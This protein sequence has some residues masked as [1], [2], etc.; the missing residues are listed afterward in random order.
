MG[1]V[2]IACNKAILHHEADY[3]VYM[4]DQFYDWY[5]DEVKGFNGMK[6]TH[7]WNKYRDGVIFAKNLGALGLSDDFTEGLFHGGNAAYL[8]LNLAYVMGGDPIYLLGVD[9]CYEK[10]KTHFHDGYDKEDTIGEKRFEHML[11]AFEYGS[12][13][14]KKTPRMVYNCSPTSKLTCFT[15]LDRDKACNS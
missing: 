2:T 7:S 9:L 4:D 1:H 11:K 5:E 13:L 10:G 12:E 14:I 8:A 6:F 3:M 15:K